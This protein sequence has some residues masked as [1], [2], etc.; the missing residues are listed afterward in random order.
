MQLQTWDLHVRTSPLQY[1][2]SKFCINYQ[3]QSQCNIYILGKEG[4]F[5]KFFFSFFKLQVVTAFIKGAHPVPPIWECYMMSERIS[6][7]YTS[8]PQAQEKLI[9]H[10]QLKYSKK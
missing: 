9:H 4:N 5:F 7:T 8:L 2:K 6:G 3:L 10:K 1:I